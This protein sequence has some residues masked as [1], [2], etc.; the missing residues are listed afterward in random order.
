VLSITPV[1][2]AFAEGGGGKGPGG[3]MSI[4]PLI[5]LFVIF[6]FLLIRP[7]QKKSKQHK[8]MLSQVG[9]GDNIITTGGIHARVMA[10]SEDTLTIEI[11]NNV[12]VKVS[13]SA[14]S[15]RKAQG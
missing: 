11:A 4:A 12:K 13:R 14:V 7:Q 1:A 5:I 9:Q 15:V 2:I 6:Y 10:V 8:E 3:I